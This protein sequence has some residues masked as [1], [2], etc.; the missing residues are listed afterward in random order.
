MSARAGTSSTP[1]RNAIQPQ[2]GSSPRSREPVGEL[3]RPRL[4][5]DGDVAGDVVPDRRERRVD[6]VLGGGLVDAE[7]DDLVHHRAQRRRSARRTVTP[8]SSTASG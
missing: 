4:R 1:R 6:S 7:A 3:G 8:P 5:G 2:P